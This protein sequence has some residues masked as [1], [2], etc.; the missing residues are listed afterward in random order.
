VIFPREQTLKNSQPTLTPLFADWLSMRVTEHRENNFWRFAESQCELGLQGLL[1]RMAKPLIRVAHVS[2]SGFRLIDWLRFHSEQSQS[3]DEKERH[4]KDGQDRGGKHAADGA[5][6]DRILTAG[7]G[8]ARDG[9]RHD[10]HDKG[11]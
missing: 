6:P 8:A 2:R 7:T 9:Q 4:E 11:E 1:R 10:A 3:G 5:C